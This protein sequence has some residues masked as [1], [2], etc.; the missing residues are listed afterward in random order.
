MFF[1]DPFELFNDAFEFPSLRRLM[2]T[3]GRHQRHRHTDRLSHLLDDSLSRAVLDDDDFWGH[4]LS[5]PRHP[6][7]GGQTKGALG[8]VYRIIPTCE[9]EPH[10][11]EHDD[12]YDEE[13]RRRI[14][15]VNDRFKKELEEVRAKYEGEMRQLIQQ[16]QEERRQRLSASR[17][18]YKILEESEE[19]WRAGQDGNKRVFVQVLRETF[20][21]RTQKVHEKVWDEQKQVLL[22]EDSYCLSA[23]GQRVECNQ[24]PRERQQQLQDE[25]SQ[26]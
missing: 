9:I 20:S 6:V 25:E 22:K 19:V 4:S 16:Q 18:P 26:V 3:Q 23:Q 5:H 10:R 12:F 15:E 1:Q 14:G 11:N 21:D 17:T 13:Y 24:Q 7:G 8:D 2:G